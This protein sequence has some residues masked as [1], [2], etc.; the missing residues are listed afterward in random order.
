[1]SFPSMTWLCTLFLKKRKEKTKN[2]FFPLHSISVLEQER[3][4]TTC[5]LF[6]TARDFLPTFFSPKHGSICEFILFFPNLQKEREKKNTINKWLNQNQLLHVRHKCKTP[7]P[8]VICS[9][10]YV[11]CFT[12]VYPVVFFFKQVNHQ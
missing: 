9:Y 10:Y 2:S 7:F 3:K 6:L 8:F 1:M 11:F 12:M 5:I 4:L